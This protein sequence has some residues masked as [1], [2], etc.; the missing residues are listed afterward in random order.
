VD[1]LDELLLD[2]L[3]ELLLFELD[4]VLLVELELLS[5]LACVTGMEV[6][7]VLLTSVVVGSKR[8]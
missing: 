7:S 2:G 3:D 4:E 1:E 8:G 5:L 6:E